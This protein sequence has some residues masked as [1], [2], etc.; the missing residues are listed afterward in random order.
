VSRNEVCICGHEKHIHTVVFVGKP[1]TDSACR[2]CL[3][4]RFRAAQPGGP[5]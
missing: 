2:M 5:K 1:A 3:C 4:R